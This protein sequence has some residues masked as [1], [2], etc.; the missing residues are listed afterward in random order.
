MCKLCH[1]FEQSD[2]VYCRQISVFEDDE[3]RFVDTFS[4]HQGQV[5]YLETN[6]KKSKF[7][8]FLQS[9]KGNFVWSI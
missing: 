2:S 8:K 4:C 5:V 9:H 7:P 3:T 6:V 1:D